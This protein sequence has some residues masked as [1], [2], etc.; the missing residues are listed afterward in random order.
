M[1][2]YISIQTRSNPEHCE[3]LKVRIW[4]TEVRDQ[5]GMFSFTDMKELESM[6]SIT[7]NTEISCIERGGWAIRKRFLL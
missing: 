4:E 7:N 2:N 1:E 3:V 5:T 6:Y